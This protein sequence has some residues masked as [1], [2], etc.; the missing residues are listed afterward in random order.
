MWGHN[1][2]KSL[3][4]IGC[5][6]GYLLAEAIDREYVAFGI[7]ISDEAIVRTRKNAPKASVTVAD[8]SYEVPEM[9]NVDFITCIGV[10]EHIIF[11]EKTLAK[12]RDI[13][14][15]KAKYLIVVPNKNFIPFLMGTEQEAL[16]E[17]VMYLEDWKIMFEK[18]GFVVESV[19]K[20][21]S[22]PLKYK[23]VQRFCS[24]LLLS[25]LPV[26][27]SYQLCFVLTKSKS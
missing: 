21:K 24:W 5:G 10:L 3:C 27:M 15:D 22:L 6:D 4:D 13:G 20:D 17:D 25:V 12:I 9:R 23:P 1:F 19:S 11:P 8:I 18:A 26:S 16:K 7:D 2:R 14:H